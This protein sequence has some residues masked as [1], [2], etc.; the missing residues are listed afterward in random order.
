[1]SPLTEENLKKMN[2]QGNHIRRT[3]RTSR[4]VVMESPRILPFPYHNDC[5][6]LPTA[7][8]H[9]PQKRR[10]PAGG[11]FS[12]LSLHSN[13]THHSHAYAPRRAASAPPIY[14][15]TNNLS[16]ASSSNTSTSSFHKLESFFL[17]LLDLMKKKRNKPAEITTTTRK[18]KESLVWFAEFTVNPP[19][20]NGMVMAA[21]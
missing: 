20:P 12:D 7:E 16:S 3:R 4:D 1:M 14:R 13:R 6:F 19:P 21:A 11:S 15:P 18:S 8:Q 9:H 5:H 2:Q 10:T 17:R